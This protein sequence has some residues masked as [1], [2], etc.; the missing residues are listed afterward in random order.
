MAK[1]TGANTWRLLPS[2]TTTHKSSR[3]V[4]ESAIVAQFYIPTCAGFV[5]V[6]CNPDLQARAQ[7]AQEKYGRQQSWGR[8]FGGLFPK[9][10]W[11][12]TGLDSRWQRCGGFWCRL[13]S[14]SGSGGFWCRWLLIPPAPLVFSLR[15]DQTEEQ[16]PPAKR[17]TD[18]NDPFQ[19]NRPELRE[20]C[21]KLET[22]AGREHTN[23]AFSMGACDM[24]YQNAIKLEG[25]GPRPPGPKTPMSV[26][27]KATSGEPAKPA[28]LNCQSELPMICHDRCGK[29]PA[30]AANSC[31]VVS[32]TEQSP[33]VMF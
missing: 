20:S 1:P 6:L 32:R 23:A 33:R 17:C 8:F 21:I 7:K 4:W 15:L 30:T 26:D 10:F 29:G 31:D 25:H 27:I 3:S 24:P 11:S 13:D 22:S 28:E 18:L 2:L 9:P 19:K 12:W 14:W 5:S 16:L